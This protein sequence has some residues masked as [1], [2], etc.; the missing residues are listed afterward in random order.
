MIWTVKKHPF[1]KKNFSMR[2]KNL[3]TLTRDIEKAIRGLVYVSETDSGF[4]VVCVENEKDRTI[5]SVVKELAK[6][7]KGKVKVEPAESFF[8]RLTTEKSWHSEEKR[9]QTEKFR[10]LK[11][12]LD[13]HLSDVMCCKI[14]RVKIEIFILGIYEDYLVGVRTEAVE[15]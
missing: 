6:H 10:K 1:F 8:E 15:T 2:S 5:E 7:A 4:S 13:T 12:L 9:K 3:H 14:G 11:S